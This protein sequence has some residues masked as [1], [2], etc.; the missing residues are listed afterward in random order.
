MIT[1]NQYFITIQN[2]KLKQSTIIK[3]EFESD[4][5]KVLKCNCYSD[6]CE[7]FEMEEEVFN[8]RNER[9]CIYMFINN[10]DSNKNCWLYFVN[11]QKMFLKNVHNERVEL[12]GFKIQNPELQAFLDTIENR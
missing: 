7:Y 10:K 12:G 3:P 2:D 4:N 5:W 1:F 9:G 8:I 6:F 11:Q